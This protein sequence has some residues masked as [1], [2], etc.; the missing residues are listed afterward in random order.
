MYLRGPF[1]YLDPI[2]GEG[3]DITLKLSLLFS[4]IVKLF[5]ITMHSSP[6]LLLL[7]LYLPWFDPHNQLL[8]K[9]DLLSI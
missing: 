7:V 9:Q 5:A 1:L 4:I 8:H 2:L 6:H 3:P